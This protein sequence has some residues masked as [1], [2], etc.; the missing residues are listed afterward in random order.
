MASEAERAERKHWLGCQWPKCERCAAY[1]AEARKRDKR[2]VNLIFST[3]WVGI[4]VWGLVR[5]VVL[6]FRGH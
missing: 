3:I 1:L 2:R 5:I 4:G 6:V